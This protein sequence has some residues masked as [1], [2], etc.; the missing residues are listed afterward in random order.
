MSEANS[1]R[2]PY[3]AEGTTGRGER[4]AS[5]CVKVCAL[6]SQGYCT[7]C[8]RTGDEIARWTA[9]SPAE[10]WQLIALLEARRAQLG[11]SG[12]APQD[13]TRG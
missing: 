6:D 2:L 9:M 8:L 3:L 5:P 7:G 13:K 4:P 12:Q 11:K 10:Q 1:V